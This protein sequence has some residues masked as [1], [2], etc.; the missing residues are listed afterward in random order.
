MLSVS[1]PYPWRQTLHYSVSF[2]SVAIWGPSLLPCLSCLPGV[3]GSLRPVSLLLPDL[4]LIL[5]HCIFSETLFN[6]KVG[7]L[8][9][10][11]T[12]ILFSLFDSITSSKILI[13]HFYCFS[14]IFSSG[15]F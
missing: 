7:N 11:Y 10:I 12:Y 5:F 15:Y 4:L 14:D 9:N 6:A 8:R 3:I 1:G 13:G 2:S